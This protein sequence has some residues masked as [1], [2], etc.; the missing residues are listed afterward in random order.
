MAEEM[1]D[2][3]DWKPVISDEAFAYL[4][5]Q[6]GKESHLLGDRAA[7]EAAYRAN[8]IALYGN[9]APFLP[10]TCRAMI[11][12]GAGMGGIDALIYQRYGGCKIGL[13]DGRADA[14]V[15]RRHAETFSSFDAARNFL[16]ANGVRP[17][18]VGL[19]G[20]SMLSPMSDLVVSFAAWCFHFGPSK[21]LQQIRREIGRGAT[22]ILEL[23]KAHRD[24]RAELEDVFGAGVLIAAGEKFERLVFHAG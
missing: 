11:D 6:R 14:P 5:V 2:L 7:W 9:I 15:V 1:I 17:D 24:W 4:A 8:L 13:I 10:K 18:D 23:R 16:E 12:V 19:P 21:Y 3:T 22:L 20:N